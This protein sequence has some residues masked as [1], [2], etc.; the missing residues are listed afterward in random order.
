VDRCAVRKIY[1]RFVGR[2]LD[3]AAEAGYVDALTREF[4]ARDR[5]LKPFIKYLLTQ[6][7][8][9]RGL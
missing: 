4:V 6:S 3:P 2:E 9:R 8:F 1:A 7:E 5:K